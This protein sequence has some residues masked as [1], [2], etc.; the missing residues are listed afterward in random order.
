MAG[1][2]KFFVFSAA[3][4]LFGLA[5]S[6]SVAEIVIRMVSP[7][8]FSSQLPLR[9]H[10]RMR[11]QT[12][13]AGLS[14]EGI[15]S[16]NRLGL[17]GDEP[18]E[19]WEV[20]FTLLAIGGSTTHCFWLDDHKTWPY[21]LQENLRPAFGNIW[22]GNGGLVG[23]TT[24]P[25]ILFMEQVAAK[26]VPDTVVLL[27]GVNDLGLS[28]SYDK[29]D[30]THYYDEPRGRDRIFSASRL[31]QELRRWKYILFQRDAVVSSRG[32][33]PFDPK[34][35]PS[36]RT[37][38]LGDLYDRLPL[39][40]E[41]R[42]NILRISD[43]GEAH[44]IETIFLTQPCLFED[45][46]Y[47]SA[48]EGDT[49]WIDNKASKID[50]ATFWK[51]LQVYNRELMAVTESRGIPCYDLAA[52]IPHSRVYFRDAVHFTEA[53]AELV[54]EHV[55]QFIRDRKYRDARSI[56]AHEALRLP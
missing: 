7:M 29:G 11:I 40:A 41:Y 51:L 50:A 55:A 16:T 30:S 6:L 45:T 43:I 24:R 32:L 13:I 20:A 12:E 14:R 56:T 5:L 22:V 2:A 44:S 49:Y 27:V 26:L 21:L 19:N 15:H 18:P 3:L 36:D 25:H 46:P 10:L 4:A 42:E 23:Q 37:V 39:L 34:P 33:K 38:T 48:R 35:L 1:R 8:P 9:P 17:R 31:L 54:A 47:W 28:L 53:G 52:A